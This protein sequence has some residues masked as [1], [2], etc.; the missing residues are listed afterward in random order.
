MQQ[1][2]QYIRQSLRAVCPPS[3]AN[4]LARLILEK[5]F[6]VS[7]LDVY[8]GKDIHF[9]PEQTKEL[10]DILQRLRRGEPVQYILGE[11][12]FCGLV[13][14]VD[15]RVLIPRPET[16]ELVDWIVEEMP[17]AACRILDIG[18][19]SGCIP[20]TLS[21]RFPSAEVV[22]WD[23]SSGA[24]AVARE[25]N[26]RNAASVRFEQRDVLAPQEV[27]ERFD[28]IVSNPPYVTLSEKSEMEINVLDW[29]PEQALFVP[30]E[31][32][33]LF[34]KRIAG[35]GKE[36]LNPSGALYFEI[37]RAY[38]AEMKSMLEGLGYTRIELRKDLSGNDRMIRAR[39]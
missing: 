5:R 39:L 29:E 36:L 28:L 2:V 7:M 13:F 27:V 20:V 22:A 3:E 34:Y 31:N 23:I 6:G 35:L 4:A 32:P 19:G 30:D 8:M 11:A 16:A 10:E 33:L 24:L 38:G 15:R 18:T 12:D 9:L 1:L 14:K 17:A 37:N 26:F 21:R 25:N